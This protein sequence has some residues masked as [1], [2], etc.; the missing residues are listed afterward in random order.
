MIVA[1][2]G[3]M[4]FHCV[5]QWS[6]AAAELALAKTRDNAMSAAAVA[7]TSECHVPSSYTC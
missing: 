7:F 3:M 6:G 4:G 1:V 2:A 5:H